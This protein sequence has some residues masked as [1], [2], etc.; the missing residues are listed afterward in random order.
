[1]ELFI[2]T[3]IAKWLT[4]VTFIIAFVIWNSSDIL[5]GFLKYMFLIGTLCA[6]AG[7]GYPQYLIITNCIIFGILGIIWRSHNNNNQLVKAY[8]LILS[9]LHLYI[10]TQ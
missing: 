8:L 7:S 3:F 1:M 2:L 9:F 5:N 6:M 10:L 4:F